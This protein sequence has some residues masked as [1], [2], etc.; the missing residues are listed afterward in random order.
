M[1]NLLFMAIK[2][3][4]HIPIGNLEVNP[5]RLHSPSPLAGSGAAY[6]TSRLEALSPL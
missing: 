6:L 4:A 5:I 2:K 3:G 1:Q